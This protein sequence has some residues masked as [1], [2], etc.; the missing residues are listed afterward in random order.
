[1]DVDDWYGG[2]KTAGE[3]DYRRERDDPFRGF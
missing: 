3:E 1:M 2:S